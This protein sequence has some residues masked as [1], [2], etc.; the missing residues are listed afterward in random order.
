MHVNAYNFIKNFRIFTDTNSKQIHTCV[1]VVATRGILL[2]ENSWTGYPVHS[3]YVFPCG[4]LGELVA[5]GG[6]LVVGGVG[7][8]HGCDSCSLLSRSRVRVDATEYV[9]M[10]SGRFYF[11]FHFYYH[12][13]ASWYWSARILLGSIAFRD[14]PTD[15]QCVCTRNGWAFFATMYIH[16]KDILL[17]YRFIH[18][19]Q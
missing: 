8:L 15:S 4:I 13:R 11:I 1:V 17:K 18:C 3:E 16:S 19:D 7:F 2:G 5:V 9:P 12:S 10:L 6:R 14:F